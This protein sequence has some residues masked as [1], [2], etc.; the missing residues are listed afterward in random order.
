MTLELVLAGEAAIAAVPAP[1]NRAREFLRGVSA[2]LGADVSFQIR[3]ALCSEVALLLF[4][5]VQS[6]FVKLVGFGGRDGVVMFSTRVF[7]ETQPPFCG[8]IA[9]LFFAQ[10]FVSF[11]KVAAL[12]LWGKIKIKV[13]L[14]AGKLTLR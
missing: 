10:V 8:K 7:C 9:V 14:T 5:S 13:L 1:R 3:P 4:A 11:A 12:V 2:V 6:F